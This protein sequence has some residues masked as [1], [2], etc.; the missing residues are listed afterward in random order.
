VPGAGWLQPGAPEAAWG[1]AAEPGWARPGVTD[2][3]GSELPGSAWDDR[4]GLGVPAGVRPTDDDRADDRPARPPVRV[5]PLEVAGRDLVT[6]GYAE[7]RED[8]VRAGR[9]SRGRR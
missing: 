5:T 6:A 1:D 7:D 4:V 2:R 8:L 9:R 3:P